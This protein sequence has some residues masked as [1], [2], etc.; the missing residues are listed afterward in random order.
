VLFKLCVPG[1]QTY[2]VARGMA[3]QSLYKAYLA[4]TLQGAFG[5]SA[6]RKGPVAARETRELP[7][8]AHYQPPVT[9][10]CNTSVPRGRII[11]ATSNFASQS[12]R[13][14]K[15]DLLVRNNSNNYNN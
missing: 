3:A 8:P 5:S 4:T 11:R 12:Q 6:E 10:P 15:P 9:T 13:I 7:G 14:K 1:P 2:N